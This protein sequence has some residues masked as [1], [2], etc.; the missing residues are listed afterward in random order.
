MD[1]VILAGGKGTR[2]KPYTT[3]IPKPLM[4]IGD[5]AILE[6][7]LHQ[8]KK[9]G[10]RKIIMAVGYKSHLFR[11][12]FGDGEKFGLPISYVTENQP[13]GTAG[14]LANILPLVG[15]D[16]IVM[17]G[18]VLTDLDYRALFS[19]HCSQN[20]KATVAVNRREVDIDF[21][22][23]HFDKN[24]CLTEYSEK[25]KHYFYVSMGINVLNTEA[26]RPHLVLGM[27]L[28]MPD[29]I[30]KVKASGSSVKCYTK[31]CFWLDVGR[32]EDFIAAQNI[33]EEKQ[34]QFIS[35]N[36]MDLRTA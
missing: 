30:T 19:F 11:A 17:N 6:V 4:P 20:S 29:L 10:A 13:L 31:P 5:H 25:P 34:N 36:D 21:G 9:A 1:V 24:E 22:V 27:R 2:L 33:F 26:I 32:Q 28:D 14:A 3:V 16:F 7:I 12:I 8:L 15:P 23:I 18:D 35:S